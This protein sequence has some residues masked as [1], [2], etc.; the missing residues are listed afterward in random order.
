[1]E[2]PENSDSKNCD[3]KVLRLKKAIYGLKQSARAWYIKVESSLLNLGFKKSKYEPCLF[4]KCHDDVKVYVAIFVDDFFVFYNCDNIYKE[5]RSV[6]EE[7]VNDN[8]SETYPYQQKN[9]TDLHGFVD[10]DWA[11][12]NIDRRSYTG[13]CF[14]LSGSVISY[15]SRKKGTVALSST[16]AE[17]MALAEACK[18]AI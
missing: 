17:Y 10:A 3:N 6:L 4:M 8:C 9:I 5:M 14:V 13:Y 18:E 11:S 15:E 2:I 12:C 7:A 16:E 1:M